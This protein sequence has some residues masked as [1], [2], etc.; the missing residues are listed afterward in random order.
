MLGNIEAPSAAYGVDRP[1][2]TAAK[3]ISDRALLQLAGLSTHLVPSRFN[4][5]VELSDGGK[6]VYNTFSAA[7]TVVSDKAFQKF[8]APDCRVFL[9][10]D[11]SQGTLEQLYS[12]G[13]CVIENTDEIELVR[14]HYQR[15][16]Y[17][18]ATRLS[19]NILPT[20]GCNLACSYCFQGM[21][22]ETVKPRLMSEE[23]AEAIIRYLEKAVVGRKGLSVSWFGGEPLLGRRTIKK[24]SPRLID[25]CERL[26]AEY[27]AVITTNAVLLTREAVRDLVEA[28]IGNAQVSIDIPSETRN[29]KKGRDTQ[30]KVL[31]NLAYAADQIGIHL[32]INLSRDDIDE[33][34]RLYEGILERG[35]NDRIKSINIAN[36]FQPE[37]ARRDG[38]GSDV[39]HRQ[40]VSV[41]KRQRELAGKFGMPIHESVS[42]SCASGCAA[43]N[44]TAVSIDP[45]G[46]LYKCPDDAGSPDRAFGSVY[47]DR[48]INQENLLS[49]LRYDWF[50]YEECLDCSMLPQCAGGCPHRRRFQ[51]E[52]HND[53]YCYWFLRG[54]LVGRVRETAERIIL[55][56]DAN[57]GDAHL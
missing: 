7:L 51:P 40:Y 35:L 34:D 4:V 10:G 43:T 33:W 46:L 38:V 27:K 41:M 15:D 5:T 11:G 9:I 22:Q 37:R 3:P 52:L 36:V 25:I 13:F 8:L 54:D 21:I 18:R 31:D 26:D 19:V 39:T 56:K 53:D 47:F 32:R 42:S 1:Q 2:R 12:R 14:Q 50:Q 23:T 6:A 17:N 57:S 55:E 24:M 49:W 30:D 44:E 29:D 20:M 45:E 48:P 16:R 28:R